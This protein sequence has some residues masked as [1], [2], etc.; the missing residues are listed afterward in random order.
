VTDYPGRLS[1]LQKEI[2]HTIA[3]NTINVRDCQ[4]AEERHGV[5]VPPSH[6]HRW[7][8]E[9]SV[10][11]SLALQETC[12]RYWG[13]DVTSW[14][15]PSGRTNDNINDKHRVSFSNSV[16]N[17]VEKKGLVSAYALAWIHIG[18]LPNGKITEDWQCWQGGGRKK[19]E[20]RGKY[21]YK[22]D[23]PRY[24]LLSLSSDG[25]DLVRELFDDR[26]GMCNVLVNKIKDLGDTNEEG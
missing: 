17:L 14:R 1:G 20:E 4:E 3:D 5:Y 2:L 19:R 12:E 22:S 16:H 8:Q 15:E 9:G 10:S 11:Y 25:W 24:K 18:H 7:M 23:R 13:V 6:W 26:I 21:E